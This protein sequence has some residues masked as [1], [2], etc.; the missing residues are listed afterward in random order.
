MTL[1]LIRHASAGRRTPN[2][3]DD[4]RSLDETGRLQAKRIGAH[5]ADAG[6]DQL[7][8]SPAR[9]CIETVEPLAHATRTGIRAL[10]DLFEGQGP[11][12]ALALIDRLATADVTAALCSHGDVIPQIIDVLAASGVPM[13][14]LG[15]AKGSIW[16]LTVADG[17]VVQGRYLATP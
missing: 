12:R 5:L 4:T 3:N 2:Q 7:L 1:Y 9:R 10:D 13:N 6:I 15:C 17:V 11:R 8:S 16:T 14:G